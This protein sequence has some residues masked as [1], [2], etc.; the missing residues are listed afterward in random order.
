MIGIKVAL[1]ELDNSIT[2]SVKFGDGSRVEIRGRG[3]I[4]SRC[5]NDKHRALMDVYYIPRLRFSIVSWTSTGAKSGSR[6]VS[7]TSTTRS[8]AYLT[9]CSAHTTG[10]TYSS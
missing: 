1:S 10:C 2:G 6:T 7:S 8:T 9:R 4:M 5:L 3:I